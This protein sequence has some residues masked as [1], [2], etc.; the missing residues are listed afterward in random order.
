[1]TRAQRG[2]ERQGGERYRQSLQDEAP[3]QLLRPISESDLPA[4][5]AV[6]RAGYL[7]P[8][9]ESVFADSLRAGHHCWLVTHGKRVIAHGIM[10]VAAG[11]AHILN[12]CVHPQRQRRGVGRRDRRAPARASR[13]WPT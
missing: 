12:L 9:A 2:L 4:V 13:G 3:Q 10:M 5:V 8:W 11:E 1:M 6:E 7:H